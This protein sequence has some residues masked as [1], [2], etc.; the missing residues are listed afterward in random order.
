MLPLFLRAVSASAVVLTMSLVVDAI[1]ARAADIGVGVN[2]EI[3]PGAPPPPR[4]EAVP[5]PPPGRA[6]VVVWVH[7]R[8]R[9]DGARYDWVPGHYI[10]RP[11]REARW[12]EG[13]WD[14]R[15]GGWVWVEGDWR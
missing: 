9:W 2:L 8:W 6:E 14:H 5:P 10:E 13:H 3:A 4:Y 12:H 1:A 11:R 15:P 7:G